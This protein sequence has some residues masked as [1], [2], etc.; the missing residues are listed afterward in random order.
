MPTT[1]FLAERA[2]RFD[3]MHKRSPSERARICLG[4]P[5]I[6]KNPE[7]VHFV[8]GIE[9]HGRPLTRAE[10]ERLNDIYLNLDTNHTQTEEAA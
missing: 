6:Q 8:Q 4:S 10:Q 2:R 3:D 7:M 5:S 1:N 9:R